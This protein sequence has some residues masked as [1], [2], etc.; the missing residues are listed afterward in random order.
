MTEFAY[1]NVKNANTSDISFKLNCGYFFHICYKKILIV[2]PG[3][4]PLT[5]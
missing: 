3:L 1:N 4:S 2:A 5:S